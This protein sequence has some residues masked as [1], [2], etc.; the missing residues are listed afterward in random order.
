MPIKTSGK[1][2]PSPL[3]HAVIFGTKSKPHKREI[4]GQYQKELYL[5]GQHY[6]S[7]CPAYI[8]LMFVRNGYLTS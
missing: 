1:S 8:T 5:N 7:I 2:S 3:R 4:I 6:G